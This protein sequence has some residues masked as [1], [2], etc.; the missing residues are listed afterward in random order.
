MESDRCFI[1]DARMWSLTI[2][3]FDP[4]IDSLLNLFQGYEV[5]IEHSK[6]FIFESGIE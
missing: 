3:L 4:V 5:E 6:A 2:I 1:S